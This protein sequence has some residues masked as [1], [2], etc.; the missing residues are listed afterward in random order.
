[1]AE[2]AKGGKQHGLQPDED[3]SYEISILYSI[4]KDLI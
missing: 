1:M 4:F 3:S 2:I